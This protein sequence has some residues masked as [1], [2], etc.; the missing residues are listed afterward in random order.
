MASL[1]TARFY[2]VWVPATWLVPVIKII[3]QSD[4]SVVINADPME[5]VNNWFYQYVF[6]DYSSQELYFFSIDWGTLLADWDRYIDNINQ[7]DSYGNKTTRWR[8]PDI[9]IDP[10]AIGEAVRESKTKDHK[11]EWTFG[12]IVQTPIS[13]GEIIVEFNKIG[14]K[15][16][17]MIDKIKLPKQIDNSKLI[18][19]ISKDMDK[20]LWDMASLLEQKMNESHPVEKMDNTIQEIENLSNSIKE[21]QDR[22]S[23]INNNVEWISKVDLIAKLQNFTID[24]LEK[25]LLDWNISAMWVLGRELKKDIIDLKWLLNNLYIRIWM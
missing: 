20:K 14:D 3:K 19:W 11:K 24:G 25:K 21:L 5:E 9:I 22:V 17:T 1:I 13:F 15:L 18:A 2:S 16:W 10:I 6:T 12:A 4:K 23:E 7:F 8:K